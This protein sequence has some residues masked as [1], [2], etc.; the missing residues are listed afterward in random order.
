MTRA[1]AVFSV[2]A[3]GIRVRVR[4]MATILEVDREYRNGK[5]C[6][7][8]KHANAYFVS[9][10]G[11][12]ARHLGT[13]ALPADG[14]LSELVPHEVV[15]AVMH[16]LGSALSSDDEELATLV[17]MLTARIHSRLGRLGYGGAT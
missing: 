11:E 2:G 6:R 17:G 12:K 15:H 3:G 1:L 4:L 8:G 16:L 7:D 10:Q 13:I 5:R 14:R 9:T